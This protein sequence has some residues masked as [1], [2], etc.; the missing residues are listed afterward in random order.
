MTSSIDLGDWL[1]GL[2]A[3][4]RC[5][6]PLDKVVDIHSRTNRILPSIFHPVPANLKIEVFRNS[7]RGLKAVMAAIKRKAKHEFL[8]KL[9]VK[10]PLQDRKT[11]KAERKLKKLAALKDVVSGSLKPL[12]P[13]EQVLVGKIIDVYFPWSKSHRRLQT[14]QHQTYSVLFPALPMG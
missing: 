10:S 1:K 4:K 11:V 2:R 13:G 9:A 6:P 7:R 3:K 5:T 12:A 8:S 14:F